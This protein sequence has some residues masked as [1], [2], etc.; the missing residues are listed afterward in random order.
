[1]AFSEFLNTI[2]FISFVISKWKK[3]TTIIIL[4]VSFSLFYSLKI[5]QNCINL[6]CTGKEIFENFNY[7]KNLSIIIFIIEFV[8]FLIWIFSVHVRRINKNKI[9][10][11]FA[12]ETENLKQKKRLSSSFYD[13]VVEITKKSTRREIKTVLLDEYYSQRLRKDRQY[14]KRLIKKINAN[15]VLYGKMEERK[16][17]GKDVYRIDFNAIVRHKFIPLVMSQRICAEM[18]YALPKQ[19]NFEIDNELT[20]F[21]ITSEMIGEAVNFIL[22]VSLAYSGVYNEA[23]EMHQ[24]CLKITTIKLNEN[25]NDEAAKR[26]NQRALFYVVRELTLLAQKSRES[27]DLKTS[28]DY[29]NK[30]LSLNPNDYESL[31]EKSVSSFLNGDI[32]EAMGVLDKCSSNKADYTWAYN[33]AFLYV[34]EAEFDMAYRIYKMLADKP[35]VINVANQCEIFIINYLEKNPEKYELFYALGMIYYKI[36]ED[37]KLAIEAF[38]MFISNS[39]K[40]NNEYSATVKYVITMKK[41][42]EKK[43]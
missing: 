34:F 27:G 7:F 26:I 29:I 8:V 31:L 35:A 43:I 2:D 12:I 30:A 42:C 17:K 14:A 5:F 16:N 21:S 41:K 22:G 38:E 24:N 6:N 23:L 28:I 19:V 25:K 20:C 9:G 32:K 36:K 39:K 11:V 37:Y 3:R 40:H 18:I 15:I 10:I 33:K 13:Q 1:M 4:E